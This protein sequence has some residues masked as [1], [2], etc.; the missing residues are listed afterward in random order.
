MYDPN[1]LKQML[2]QHL[3]QQ[4]QQVPQI[5]NQDPKI[6]AVPVDHPEAG[7][8]FYMDPQNQIQGAFSSEQMSGW[9][10]AG[11]FTEFLM[12]KRG[13]DDKFL[14]LGAV[15]SNWGRIP[16]ASGYSSPP[17]LITQAKQQPVV[18]QLATSVNPLA[19]KE[20]LIQ[21]MQLYQQMQQL[22]QFIPQNFGLLR[23][24]FILWNFLKCNITSEK[25]VS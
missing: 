2:Q 22:Q 21:Q 18:Q 3:Q 15:K 14:P 19:S 25:S 5:V 7:H 20:Q 13:C 1:A 23:Y 6:G 12:I 4:Q 17:P 24:E 11:Y 8:W 16:F 9:L 10:S